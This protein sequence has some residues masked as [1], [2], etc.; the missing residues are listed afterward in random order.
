MRVAATDGFRAESP[1]QAGARYAKPAVLLPGQ[2]VRPGDGYDGQFY[3]YLAQDPFLTRPAT[4][5]AL[6]N[7]FRVRRILYPL[8]AWAVSLGR[9]EALPWVLLLLNIAASAATVGLA[10]WAAARQG[11]SAW[12]ALALAAYAG[13]WV[14]LLL[15][16]TEPL[17]LA[18]LAAGMLAGS[19]PLLFLAAL[20]KETAG[21]ALVTEAVRRRSLVHGALAVLY[22]AW[23]LFVFKFVKG[24]VFN[25]LGAHFLDP[26]GAPFRLL[27]TQ[28]PVHALVLAPAIL[29]CLL[30]VGRLVT[31]RDGAA[32]AAAAYALLALGAGNDT[33]LDPAAFY[34]VTAGALLLTYLSWCLRGDRWGLAAL[35]VGAFS[36]AL[37]LPI[38]L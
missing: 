11:R 18:L 12:W 9:R 33:W 1:I 7:T 6:D 14:P 28:G 37:L 30:A 5:A 31:A 13:V 17:Q 38:L 36:G 19:G 25:D 32:W 35:L 23:A 20:A 29:I 3:F 34:R 22:L 10:A 15:D 26:P 16:L 24:T 27:L 8:V 21:V 4:A 2:Q